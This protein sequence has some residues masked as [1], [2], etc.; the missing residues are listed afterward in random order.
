MK[1]IILKSELNLYDKD[2][3]DQISRVLIDKAIEATNNSYSP[4]SNFKVGAALRLEDGTI[5]IGANQEMQHFQ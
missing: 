1:N 2:E 4:Y 5:V 3:L